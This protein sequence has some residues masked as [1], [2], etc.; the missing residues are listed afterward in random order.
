MLEKPSRATADGPAWVSRALTKTSRPRCSGQAGMRSVSPNLASSSPG[1]SVVLIH[2][3][4]DNCRP[5]GR[6]DR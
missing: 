2:I 3:V 5:G 1:P 4:L 6:L